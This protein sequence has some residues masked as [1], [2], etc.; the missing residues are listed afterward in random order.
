MTKEQTSEDMKELSKTMNH[1]DLV[2]IYRLL[3]PTKV[4]CTFFSSTHRM[5]TTV[6]YILNNKTSL[7]E[8]ERSDSSECVLQAQWSQNRGH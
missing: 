2:D 3:Y 8:F 5:Y 7:I 1:H 6:A 4:E